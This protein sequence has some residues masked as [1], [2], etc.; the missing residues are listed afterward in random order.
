MENAHDYRF[1]VTFV[2]SLLNNNV[3]CSLA[4]TS[5]SDLF[6]MLVN[7]PFIIALEISIDFRESFHPKQHAL[8]QALWHTL[9]ASGNSHSLSRYFF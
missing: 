3:V 5:K 6:Y 8:P 1:N 7:P 9:A 4:C 2:G